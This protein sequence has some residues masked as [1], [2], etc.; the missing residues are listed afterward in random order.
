MPIEINLPVEENIMIL[1][2]KMLVITFHL[3]SQALVQM[4]TD[5]HARRQSWQDW[6]ANIRSS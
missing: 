6:N 4:Q 2:S 3:L 5:H 1:F